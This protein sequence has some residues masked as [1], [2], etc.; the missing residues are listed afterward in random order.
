M[1]GVH[2]VLGTHLYEKK[3]QAQ[4]K[5]VDVVMADSDHPHR[6]WLFD[7]FTLFSPLSSILEIGCGDGVNVEILAKKNGGLNV[8]GLD[9]SSDLVA[10]GNYRLSRQG[11]DQARLLSGKADDLSLFGDKSFDLVFTDAV[12]LYVGPDKIRKVISEMKRVARKAIVLLELHRP[13]LEQ[14]SLLL[15]VH[16]RDGWIRDY[17]KLLKLYFQKDS[18]T[19][20]KIP[21][22]VWSTGRWSAYGHLMTVACGDLV[23]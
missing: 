18:I 12:L 22:D 20:T 6:R 13:S 8:V 9:I 2:S 5:T 16:T 15:G 23:S 11:L 17:E 7:K 19:L 14:K 21:R 10:A 4:T 3:W 1:G